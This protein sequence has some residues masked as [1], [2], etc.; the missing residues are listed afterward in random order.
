MS[1]IVQ[2]FTAHAFQFI[3]GALFDQTGEQ[4]ALVTIPAGHDKKPIVVLSDEQYQ[5]L[6]DDRQFK[7]LLDSQKNGIRIINEIPH[8]DRDQSDLL[9]EVNK[10]NAELTRRNAQLEAQLATVK[11]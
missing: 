7:V 11:K 5:K 6:K 4:K 1:V 8:K 9:N 2:S 3:D 10:R